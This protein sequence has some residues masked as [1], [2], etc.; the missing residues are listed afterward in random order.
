VILPGKAELALKYYQDIAARLAED[1][2]EIVG[3]DKLLDT[4]AGKN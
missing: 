2:A 1:R 3:L 4:P